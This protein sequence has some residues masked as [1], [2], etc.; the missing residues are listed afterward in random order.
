MTESE[1]PGYLIASAKRALQG[2][3]SANVRQVSVGYDGLRNL[4]MR[5][6]YDGP[7]TGDQVEDM[8]VVTSEILGN[9][10]K[11]GW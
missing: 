9:V 1:L 11:N 6:I 10:V 8:E 5:V 2:A 3:I 4:S 7:P